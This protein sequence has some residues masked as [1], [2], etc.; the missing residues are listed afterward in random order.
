VKRK[1][2]VL[3]QCC[4]NV[5]SQVCDRSDATQ[6]LGWTLTHDSTRLCRVQLHDCMVEMAE[7][8]RLEMAAAA[9]ESPGSSPTWSMCSLNSL[10]SLPKVPT[11]NPKG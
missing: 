2:A 7:A 10:S 6:G 4:D 5:C 8:I 1:P 9:Q 3:C 11:L